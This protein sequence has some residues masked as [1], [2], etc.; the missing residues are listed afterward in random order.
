MNVTDIAMIA[1]AQGHDV[2]AVNTD[3]G[4]ADM[5]GFIPLWVDG[6][7]EGV[8]PC[9]AIHENYRHGGGWQDFDGFTYNDE[10]LALEY[11][12]DPAVEPFAVGAVRP[13]YVVLMYPHSWVCVLNI[14][15]DSYRV[16]RI[17]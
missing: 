13:P 10:T 7:P 5:L 14:E 2:W 3:R 1:A 16:A 4:N 17:D 9:D 11:P 12:G 15:D 6:L 8:S